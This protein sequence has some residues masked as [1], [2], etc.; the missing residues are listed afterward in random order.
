MADLFKQYLSNN[1][2]KAEKNITKEIS[3]LQQQF[4]KQYPSADM[5][6]FKFKVDVDKSGTVTSSSIYFEDS[7][8]GVKVQ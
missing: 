5:K 2:E 8:S 4:I 1:Y 7:V 3:R 6:K